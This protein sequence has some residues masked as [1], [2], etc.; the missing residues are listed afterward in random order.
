MASKL[1]LALAFGLSMALGV[2]TASAGDLNPEEVQAEA[3]SAMKEELRRLR[4]VG[5]E[6]VRVAITPLECKGDWRG[7]I[8]S[9]RVQALRA[10]EI[11]SEAV[12]IGAQ[13]ALTYRGLSGLVLDMDEAAKVPA[14]VADFGRVQADLASCSEVNEV[15]TPLA[16]LREMTRGERPGVL[17]RALLELVG[18]RK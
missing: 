3:R 17:G 15:R 5:D 1:I 7:D 13:A 14:L 8:A 9:L 6:L 12:A 4:E 10:A 11:G 2:P 18:E 16:P